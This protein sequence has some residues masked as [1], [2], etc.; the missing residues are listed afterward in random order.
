MKKQ[1]FQSNLP[2]GS[3]RL[4]CNGLRA[5]LKTQ[6]RYK[7]ADMPEAMKLQQFMLKHLSSSLKA[8]NKR[9]HQHIVLSVVADHV[10]VADVV[11][12]A[13]R[14]SL[15]DMHIKGTRSVETTRDLCWVEDRMD[16]MKAY[17]LYPELRCTVCSNTG[18]KRS[19]LLFGGRCGRQACQE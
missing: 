11:T 10:R 12:A 3:V 16:T 13:A 1:E 7:K 8:F 9:K 19:M 2:F 15:L 18:D 17:V 5:Q 6:P 4:I 14:H